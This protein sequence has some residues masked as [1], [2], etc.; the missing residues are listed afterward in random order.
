M[1]KVVAVRHDGDG[2]LESFKLDD[3]RVL[4]RDQICAEADKG[5]IYGVSSFTT[6]DGGQAVRSD[7]GLEGYS[8]DS[9]P[10]F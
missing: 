10:E 7:R 6:R 8:L 5:H 3:G 9:L 4:N 1:S 2:N